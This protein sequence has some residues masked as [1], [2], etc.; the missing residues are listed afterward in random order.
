MPEIRRADGALPP[1]LLRH[2]IDSLTDGVVVTDLDGR[3][4]L[5]NPAAERLL[6]AG[7]AD[8]P[9][10]E[11]TSAYGCLLPD[12]VTP[13]APERLPFARSLLGE[14]V[15][16]FELFLR[17][18]S[19][20]GGL[21]LSIKSTPLRDGD[22]EIEGAIAVLHDLTNKKRGLDEIQTLSSAVE[23]TADS[24][25]I[26]DRDGRIEY[27]NPAFETI[28][29]YSR[30]EAVGQT[31]RI[32]K[33]DTH[34]SDFY[35]DLWRTILDGRVFR[36]TITN[37]KKTGELYL[38]E[39]TITP[40][41]R[42]DGGVAHVVSVAKDITQL[43]KAAEREGTLLLARSVQ[44]RLYPVGSPDLPGFDIAGAAFV[45]DV[46]GGDYFD[47][48]PLPGERLA[49]V[50]GDVS[51]HG[52]DSALLMAETRAVLRSTAQTTVEPSAILTIVNRVLT[53]D[54]EDN[55]FVTLLVICLHGPTRTFSYASAGHTPGFV[56]DA[57]DS[58]KRDLSATGV[59]LGLFP[60]AVFETS[61]E[62]TLAPGERLLL[63][64]DGVTETEAPDGSTF[65]IEQAL[66]VMRGRGADGSAQVVEALFRAAR[67]FACG[68]A[69]RDDMAI[70]ICAASAGS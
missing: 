52:V 46:T 29:G 58:V 27:V 45:A 4:L 41:K 63:L 69:Q 19:A 7:L 11:W 68:S 16:D 65:G 1:A 23:Q 2:V 50:I 37:R 35:R 8:V 15:S 64:T 6:G 22:G 32:L 66:D 9:A 51:G 31:P 42:P 60:E 18:G 14:V 70:V 24:V 59:P 67:A 54:T 55:R 10:S 47:F 33:S 34:T 61:S 39:Q 30:A 17:K 5:F 3:V 13:C 38:S 57:S 28:T 36:G 40:M 43:R 21:W 53:A 12:M 25:F 49:I 44:Q 26:T 62:I 20:P 48:V 56:V